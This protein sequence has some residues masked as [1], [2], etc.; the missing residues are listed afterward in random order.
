MKASAKSGFNKNEVAS[1]GHNPDLFYL[2]IKVLL[3]LY[4]LHIK[5]F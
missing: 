3:N 1:N 2:I 5:L 4:Y